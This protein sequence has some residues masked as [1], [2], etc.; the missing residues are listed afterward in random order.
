MYVDSL[1][2]IIGR[3]LR[4][5]RREIE[6][7]P[8]DES[9]WRTF[10]G[11]PNSGGT[12]ALHLCGN[13]RH[14]VGAVLGGSGYR[15]DRD[16]EFAR[17]G[18]TRSEL[19]RGVDDAIADVDRA[20]AA[21]PDESLGEDY[22]S[23]VGSARLRLITGDLLVHL[24]THLTYHLGQIDYHRRFVTGENGQMDAVSLKELASARAY[25]G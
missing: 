16:A 24:A 12:L 10:P 20:L 13:V 7:Y 14:F 15:R 6:A 25:E 23:P 8:D 22:P 1:R 3:D 19:A 11:A 9:V 5:L 21:L 4:T 2:A 17:R 18:V